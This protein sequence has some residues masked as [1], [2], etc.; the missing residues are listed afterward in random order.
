[1]GVSQLLFFLGWLI[2]MVSLCCGLPTVY[3][4]GWGLG[5]CGGVVYFPLWF[6]FG[7]PDAPS[8]VNLPLTPIG[9]PVFYTG[10][11]VQESDPLPAGS[12]VLVPGPLVEST[13]D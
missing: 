3:Y 11:P 2:G 4:I 12:R 10:Q 1:M 5:A 6:W 7:V 13:P 8:K 9:E